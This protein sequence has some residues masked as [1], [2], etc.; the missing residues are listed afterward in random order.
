MLQDDV[1]KAIPLWVNGHA[2][3]TVTPTFHEVREPHSR[4]VLRCTPLCGG[5]EVELSIAAAQAVLAS[6][7]GMP[8][9]ARV[10]LLSAVGGL[11][12]T[13]SEHF[14]TLIVEESGKPLLAAVAEVDRSVALLQ[15]AVA[16][17]ES[18]VVA[19]I[20]NRE[21]PLLASL[22]LAVPALAAGA[23]VVIRPN[24]ETPSALFA[25]AELTGRCGFPDGVFNIVH[26]DDAVVNALRRTS[27]VS[28]LIS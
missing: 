28:L 26:G 7:S 1:A 15:C 17:K 13:Y 22:Q 14:A 3:L 25:L 6:W 23:A 4:A 19:V 16:G 2:F 9:E 8:E 18:G 11:L 24:P 21:T 5:A 10:A 27:G 20:G 12:A